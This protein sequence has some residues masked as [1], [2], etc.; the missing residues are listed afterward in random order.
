MIWATI[1]RWL[2][3]CEHD[4]EHAGN[5]FSGPGGARQV[6]Y[7]RKCKVFKTRKWGS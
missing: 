3:L 5:R 1:R 7:C 6:M 4:W 2:G